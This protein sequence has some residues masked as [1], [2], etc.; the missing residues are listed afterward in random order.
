MDFPIWILYSLFILTSD[1]ERYVSQAS[2]FDN[3]NECIAY[4]KKYSIELSDA[5]QAALDREHGVDNY[6]ALEMGC[7]P[8][9][10]NNKEFADKRIP[11]IAIPWSMP[12]PEG[13][14]L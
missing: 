5:W 14:L 7:V 11:V 8:R 1:G 4:A 6:F 2:Q 12:G 13:E 10:K 9:D 3:R